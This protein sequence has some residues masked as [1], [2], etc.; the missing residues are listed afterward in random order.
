MPTIPFQ[1]SWLTLADVQSMN[2]G[3]L[4]VDELPYRN[5]QGDHD[6]LKVRGDHIRYLEQALQRGYG[7]N[8]SALNHITGRG[9]RADKI[10]EEEYQTRVTTLPVGP[11]TLN[12]QLLGDP[13]PGRSALC[14]KV[15]KEN[16]RDGI[17]L[18]RA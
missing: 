18:Q 7:G 15:E 6:R 2:E 12:Q 9:W 10:S 4:S 17:T 5:Q 8:Y 11:L 1:M 14:K 3:S 16:C 13:H